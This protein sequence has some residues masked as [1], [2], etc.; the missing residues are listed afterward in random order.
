MF[1]DI[2]LHKRYT[3]VAVMDENGKIVE[4][5]RVLDAN[6]NEIAQKYVGSKAAI[7]AIN[8][9]CHIHNTF[10]KYLDVVVANPGE[11]K[12]IAGSNKKTDR[13]DAMELA[14]MVGLESVWKATF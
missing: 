7:E 12:L 14:R 4:E 3:Q 5:V 11:L 1:I 8:N 2:S 10:S 13:V 6:L 9:Y